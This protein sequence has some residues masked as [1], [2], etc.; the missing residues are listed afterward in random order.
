MACSQEDPRFAEAAE[1]HTRAL[2]KRAGLGHT[3]DSLGQAGQVHRDSLTVWRQ[4]L[5]AWDESLVEVP[6][7]EHTDHD[8]HAHDHHAHR[9]Q[10]ELSPADALAV[11]QELHRQLLQLEA[12]VARSTNVTP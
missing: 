8:S 5:K 11:Q 6:G 2:R 12:R 3:L 7:Y 10:A 1:W 4:V 9:P